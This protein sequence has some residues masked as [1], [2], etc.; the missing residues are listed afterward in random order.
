[1]DC[2]IEHGPKT[3]CQHVRRTR[4]QAHGG[5]AFAPGAIARRGPDFG[6]DGDDRHVVPGSRLNRWTGVHPSRSSSETSATMMLGRPGARERQM[7]VSA[8][9]VTSNPVAARP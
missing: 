7:V 5:A 6:G 8:A 9:V 3:R 4:L 2:V 1:M